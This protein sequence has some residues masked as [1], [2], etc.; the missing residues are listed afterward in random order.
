MLLP[1]FP[2]VPCDRWLDFL[3]GRGEGGRWGE[4][5]GGG[6]RDKGVEYVADSGHG[7]SR[8]E[9]G[10]WSG[11]SRATHQLSARPVVNSMGTECGECYRQGT[12]ESASAD[13]ENVD[14]TAKNTSWALFSLLC[15]LQTMVKA[16]R[17][18]CVGSFRHTVPVKKS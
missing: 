12:R 3:E 10:M 15:A 6:G 4:G 2:L 9:L 11:F 18:R 5:A 7:K 17:E 14:T 8:K 13:C 1:V 16:Q